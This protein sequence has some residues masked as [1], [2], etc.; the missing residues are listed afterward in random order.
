MSNPVSVLKVLPEMINP[1]SSQIFTE[2]PKS[3]P[4]AA[5]LDHQISLKKPTFKPASSSNKPNIIVGR[6]SNLLP[7]NIYPPSSSNLTSEIK[8]NDVIS[9]A[10]VPVKTVLKIFV[11]TVSPSELV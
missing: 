1:L 5:F 6:T 11:A 2:N 8:S 7:T 10:F 9:E 4:F 3:F